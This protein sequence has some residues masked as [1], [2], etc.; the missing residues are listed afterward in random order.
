MSSLKVRVDSLTTTEF[1]LQRMVQDEQGKREE[2]EEKVKE[3]KERVAD[4]TVRLEQLSVAHDD[5]N[6]SYLSKYNKII[7][8]KLFLSRLVSV[9]SSVSSMSFIYIFVYFI[10]FE[11]S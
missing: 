3:L 6:E 9:S 2:K 4:L 11:F 5:I 10:Q 7:L 8:I 1:D